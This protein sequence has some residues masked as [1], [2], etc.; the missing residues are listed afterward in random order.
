MRTAAILASTLA[1]TACI[2]R[3]F[4][5]DP[6]PDAV[7][8]TF[9]GSEELPLGATADE[10]LAALPLELPLT[11]VPLRDR[12]RGALGTWSTLS[13]GVAG[14][15]QLDTEATTVRSGQT[16]LRPAI[17]EPDVCHEHAEV[18]VTAA[19]TLGDTGLD[20]AR[21]TGT[22]ALGGPDLL[23]LHLLLTCE[24][25][26]PAEVFERLKA[27]IANDPTLAGPGVDGPDDVQIR[28]ARLVLQQWNDQHLLDVQFGWST[29]RREGD[30]G[31]GILQLERGA[32]AE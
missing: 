10:A 14:L 3:P 24:D 19:W 26:A 7:E 32:P 27:A 2:A 1:A 9:R 22:A 4:D 31:H 25:Q 8:E 30:S 18:E 16:P 6:C 13:Q 23:P 28:W 12:A 21:A 20:C 5:A 29:P 15:L 11:V 17:D